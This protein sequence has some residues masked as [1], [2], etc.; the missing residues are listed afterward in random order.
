MDDPYTYCF[1]P[2]SEDNDLELKQ[3]DIDEEDS[4]A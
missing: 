2:S 4:Q 3:R 1:K